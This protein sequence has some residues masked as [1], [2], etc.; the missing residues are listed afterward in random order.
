M[1]KLLSS[2]II[3][4][5]LVLFFIWVLHSEDLKL[6]NIKNN[7]YNI[8]EEIDNISCKRLYKSGLI[9]MTIN[10][11]ENKLTFFPN[12]WKGFSLGKR[13]EMQLKYYEQSKRFKAILLQG[14]KNNFPLDLYID[15]KHIVIFNEEIEKRKNSNRNGIH[16][17][18]TL[19][20]LMSFIYF[21]IWYYKI[22]MDKIVKSI[23]FKWILYIIAIFTII[24]YIFSSRI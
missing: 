12:T 6:Y 24:S 13:C 2:T 8:E 9:E 22:D 21:L 19:G 15:K 7:I 18:F 16:I 23:K 3:T 10:Y 1:N 11:N 20:I 14:S 4:W 5:V 17:A